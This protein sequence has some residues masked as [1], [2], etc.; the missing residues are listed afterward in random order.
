MYFFAYSEVPSGN[1][2][3]PGLQYVIGSLI[4]FSFDLI[5]HLW[6]VSSKLFQETLY[7]ELIYVP[8][9]DKEGEAV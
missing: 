2:N 6:V 4:I 7:I 3:L 5:P 8:C 1:R 9:K